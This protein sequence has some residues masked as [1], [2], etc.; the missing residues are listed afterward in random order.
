MI[1]LMLKML[2]KKCVCV[3]NHMLMC[4]YVGGSRAILAHAVTSVFHVYGGKPT[5]L[6]HIAKLRHTPI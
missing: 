6:V 5:T 2:K 1:I 4:V 3:H